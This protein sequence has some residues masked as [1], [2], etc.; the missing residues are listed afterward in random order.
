MKNQDQSK[1]KEGL[2]RK[3]MKDNLKSLEL[4]GDIQTGNEEIH[5]HQ[6][7]HHTQE[8][9]EQAD[10]NDPY[11]FLAPEAFWFYLSG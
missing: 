11:P 10:Q 5:I 8:Q 2:D 9:Q 6:Y 4:Q 7:S 3:I 1:K